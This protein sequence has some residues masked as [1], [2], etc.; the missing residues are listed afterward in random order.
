MRNTPFVVGGLLFLL[1]AF[2]FVSSPERFLYPSRASQERVR[3]FFAPTE[4]SGTTS[5]L[6]PVSVY[7]QT[8][9]GVFCI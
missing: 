4:I 2:F 6:I 1:V 8:N 3:L 9:P 7:L 5:T